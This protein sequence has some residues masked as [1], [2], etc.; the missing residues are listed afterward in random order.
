MGST[1]F[2]TL[3]TTLIFL[4]AAV[5]LA[6]TDAA[7]AGGGAVL[8]AFLISTMPSLVAAGFSE[9]VSRD[10]RN[11]TIVEKARQGTVQALAETGVTDAIEQGRQT[12]PAALEALTALLAETQAGRVRRAKLSD[13]LPEPPPEEGRS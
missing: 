4:A 5:V 1:P 6:L 13:L 7:N 2:Y 12:T 11:G 8:L 10:V 9:R 3:A